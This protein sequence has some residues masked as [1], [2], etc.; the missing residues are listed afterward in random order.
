MYQH[1]ERIILLN[2]E[3]I[4]SVCDFSVCS[5]INISKKKIERE[6]EKNGFKIDVSGN[7]TSFKGNKNNNLYKQII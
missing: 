1:A 7:K 6:I 5:E 4:K 2:F 3:H